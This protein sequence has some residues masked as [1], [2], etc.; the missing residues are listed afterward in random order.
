MDDEN[1]TLEEAARRVH[2]HPDT[3][4]KMAAA[5]EVPSTK[6]GRGWLF[7]EELLNEWIRKRCL[8]TND[9]IQDFGGSRLAT[10]IA[11]RRKQRTKQKRAKLRKPRASDCG[12]KRNLATVVPFLGKRP[13]SDG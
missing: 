12:D 7:N 5:R 2:C 8:C 9:L 11:T 10:I 1:L 6:I 3:L 4:R 13:P